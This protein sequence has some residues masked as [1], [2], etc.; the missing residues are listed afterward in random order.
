MM[1]KAV[2][3]LLLLLLLDSSA[4]A[5]GFSPMPLRQVLLETDAIILAEILEN[6]GTT[7]HWD[8]GKGIFSARVVYTNDIKA[9]VISTHLGEF[10]NA[11][12]D[13]KYSLTLVK[14][15]WVTIPGSGL[16][17]QMSV[18]EK[19]VLALKN[20]N[21]TYTLQRAEKA[22][23]L[24]E[25]LRLRKELDEEDR[26][27]AEAQA[28]IPN[29]IYHLSELAEASKIRLHDGRRF[30]IGEQCDFDIVRKELRSRYNLFLLSLTLG[31]SKP[32]YCIL[33]VDGKAYWLSDSHWAAEQNAPGTERSPKLYC[34]F[35]DRSNAE[36][37]GG[38]FGIAVVGAQE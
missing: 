23:K 12:Y 37:V 7:T 24:E 5:D 21:G 25:V 36:A 29:G 30:R 1:V 17:G 16:E 2:S 3:T 20:V 38:Y 26:R 8:T 11:E 22:E 33:M 14:G 4:F 28:R 32:G 15:V 35:T 13:T 6:N 9:R 10:T 27:V 19:Y 31:S 18:G 34:E